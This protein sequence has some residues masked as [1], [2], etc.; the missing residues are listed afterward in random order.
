MVKKHVV[1]VTPVLR[2]KQ[3]WVCDTTGTF[4]AHYAVNGYQHLMLQCYFR[5]WLCM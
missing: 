5:C 1:E 4:S 2:N 3:R